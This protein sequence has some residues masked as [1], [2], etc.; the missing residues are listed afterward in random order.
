[1]LK[2]RLILVAACALT[3]LAACAEPPSASLYHDAGRV[4]PQKIAPR[5][6][7]P[8]YGRA[9]A[10]QPIPWTADSL[11]DDFIDLQFQTEWGSA[12]QSLLRWPGPVEVALVGSEL[13]AY[14]DDVADLVNLIGRSAP[15]LHLTLTDQPDDAEITI[16]TA[17]KAEMKEVANTALCF[18]AP[19]SLDWEA[20]KAADARG[21]TSWDG[22]EELTAVTIYIPANSAPHVFRICFI[23]EIMQA[24]GPGN[25]LYRLEDSGFNDD[26]VHVSPTAFDLLMLRVLYDP[27]LQPGMSKAEARA[28]A[29]AVLQRE[30]GSDDRRRP[31]MRTA[32]DAD[33]QLYHYYSD[34]RT[35]PQERRELLDR[36]NEAAAHF[37]PDDHRLG[38]ALRSEAYFASDEGRD[39]DAVRYARQAV[40]HFER[41]LPPTS[42]RLARTRADLGLFLL[43]DG[44]FIEAA[45]AFSEAEPWLAA[46]G[47][48]DDLANVMRLRAI[49]LAQSGRSGEARKIAKR[50]LAWAAY[51][52]G[53]DSRALSEW[54]KQFRDF[55]ISV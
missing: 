7:Y 32:H 20:Y 45:N 52:F 14:R 11:A 8:G 40:A 43:L 30:L 10:R 1:M 36:A 41:T 18:F 42:A 29:R 34:I 46:H 4:T 38:E 2:S 21:E 51:V 3:L 6:D 54:R 44:A 33:F 28:A 12:H 19:V 9:I 15:S 47:K 24:L 13:A 39:D 48:E 35:D 31:R 22:V 49:A 17:P 16:R 25:D 23:E 53:A 27:A 55:E 5:P 26:E 50:A 37:A